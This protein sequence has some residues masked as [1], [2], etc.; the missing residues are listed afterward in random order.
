MFTRE[1]IESQLLIPAENRAAVVGRIPGN[2][3][4][5]PVMLLAHMDVVGVE[6]EKW[7]SDPFAGVIRD[8]HVYGR[9]AFDDKGMLAANVMTMLLV[10]RG[11]EK[12]TRDLIF[13]ATSDE[14]GGGDVGIRWLVANHRDL[15]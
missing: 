5:P 15:L 9:G 8:G 4:Q 12:L 14:E 6:A 1:G 3:S 7:S 11:G 2:G 13:V 10:K